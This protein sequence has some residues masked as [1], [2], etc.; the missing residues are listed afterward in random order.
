M[1]FESTMGLLRKNR[2]TKNAFLAEDL[3]IWNTCALDSTDDYVRYTIEC[4]R[5]RRVTETAEVNSQKGPNLSFPWMV[6][7]S[8]STQIR[9]T[10]Y[11]SDR[12]D[13][14]RVIG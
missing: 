13:E 2:Q 9:V 12:V 11:P 1:Q 7:K 10:C 5:N 8:S 4:L 6:G 3:I 14:G